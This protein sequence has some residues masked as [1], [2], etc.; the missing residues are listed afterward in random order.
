MLTKYSLMDAAAFSSTSSCV[1]RAKSLLARSLCNADCVETQRN[2]YRSTSRHR[3]PLL[4]PWSV[5]FFQPGY[6]AVQQ[7]PANSLPVHT[8]CGRQCRQRAESHSAI[9]TSGERQTLTLFQSRPFVTFQRRKCSAYSETSWA[10]LSCST[11]PALKMCCN[12]SAVKVT[13]RG[14]S[15]FCRGH[16]TGSQ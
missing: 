3:G 4:S 9:Q 8:P 5:T 6:P 12:S 16:T 14:R 10:D 15:I 11:G 7:A 2:I 13:L 1:I